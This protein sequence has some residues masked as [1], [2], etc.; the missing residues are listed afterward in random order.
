MANKRINDLPAVTSTTAGDKIPIDGI[1]TRGITVEDFL[2]NK[3][4]AIGLGNV[5]NTSDANKPVSTATQA[6]LDGKQPLDADLTAL[7]GLSGTGIVRRTG[8]S[9]F[10]TGTAVANS[11]LATMANNTFKGNV[12]GATAVPADLTASQVTAALPV[13]TTRRGDLSL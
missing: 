1:T 8:A 3:K 12:S 9:T 10:S 11:E 4:S 13:A 7:A 2:A 6:A 5:D